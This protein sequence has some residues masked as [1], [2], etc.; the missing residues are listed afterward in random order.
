MTSHLNKSLGAV[1]VA[2]AT[3][4]GCAAAGDVATEW[5]MY[6][7]CSGNTDCRNGQSCTDGA[8][9]EVCTQKP[10]G[11]FACPADG[12]PKSAR[13]VVCSLELAPDRGY[14]RPRCTVT[15][16]CPSELVCEDNLCVPET[17]DGS[18]SK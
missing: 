10:S 1:L 11:E 7:S 9:T 5:H 14:C 13:G 16:D 2:V 3:L 18:V 15:S 8:C 6:T 4:I 17:A 12:I